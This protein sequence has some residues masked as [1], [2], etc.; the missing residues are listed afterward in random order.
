[1]KKNI[2]LPLGA[3]TVSILLGGCGETLAPY[4]LQLFQN[5]LEL[6]KQQNLLNLYTKE[7]LYGSSEN[8]C[9]NE[10]TTSQKNYSKKFSYCYKIDANKINRNDMSSCLSYGSGLGW[11]KNECTFITKEDLN[12]KNKIENYEMK[13]SK[14]FNNLL[15]DYVSSDFNTQYE[16]LLKDFNTYSDNFIPLIKDNTNLLSQ[17]Q[18]ENMRQNIIIRKN[19]PNEFELFYNKISKSSMKNHFTYNY[20]ISSKSPFSDNLIF[21][22]VTPDI[23]NIPFTQTEQHPFIVKEILFRYIPDTFVMEDSNLLMNINNLIENINPTK[24]ELANKSNN[25]IKIKNITIYTDGS[26]HTFQ[27]KE[28]TLPPHTTY[29]ID[30]LKYRN[31]YNKSDIWRKVKTFN[32]KFNYGWTILYNDGTQDKTLY[33]TK[34]YKIQF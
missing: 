29:T 20:S 26:I 33:S 34:D 23:K 4:N 7:N 15:T 5:K 6:H 24:I 1:M 14:D 16:L 17:E 8:G 3:I 12:L 27:D 31:I 32:D 21:N 19:Y 25:F 18:I 2:M 9:I 10:D 11:Q 30:E 13:L 28:L 22:F